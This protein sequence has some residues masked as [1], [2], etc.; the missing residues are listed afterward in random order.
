MPA[1]MPMMNE[2][3]HPDAVLEDAYV[4]VSNYDFDED[5]YDSRC[6]Y[7]PTQRCTCIQ[8]TLEESA[9]HHWFY[10]ENGCVDPARARLRTGVDVSHSARALAVTLVIPRSA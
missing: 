4:D 10:V 5:E 9:I 6:N 1:G 2:F 7:S 8:H 3:A